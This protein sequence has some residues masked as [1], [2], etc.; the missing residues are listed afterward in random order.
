MT[1]EKK[2]LEIVSLRNRI[3]KKVFLATIIGTFFLLASLW[4]LVYSTSN[5]RERAAMQQTQERLEDFLKHDIQIQKGLNS[6]LDILPFRDDLIVLVFDKQEHLL[7]AS[8]QTFDRI[9]IGELGVIE[10]VRQDSRSYYRLTSL[11]Q[12][13]DGTELYLQQYR[14]FF[15]GHIQ[16]WF[17]LVVISISILLLAISFLFTVYRTVSDEVYPIRKLNTAFR[18]IIDDSFGTKSQIL[19]EDGIL[20]IQQIADNYNQL[21]L[22]MEEQN[23]KQI[24]FISDVSHELRTPVTVLK[25]YINML[26]RWGRE[27]EVVLEESL[28][29]S[30]KEAQRMEI[31]IKDMLDM[32]RIQGNIADHLDDVTDVEESILDVVDNFKVLRNDFKFVFTENRELLPLAQIYQVH[33]EQMIV[34]LIDNAIKYSAENKEIEISATENL[35][36][37]TIQVLVRDHGQG[38]SQEDLKHIFDRF[39]RASKARTSKDTQAGVGIGLSI[40]KKLA[41]AYSIQVSVRSEPGV[42]TEFILD[43]PQVPEEK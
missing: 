26:L 27:D 10:S 17:V 8:D 18:Q 12:L 36:K 6:Y 34:I 40:L 7:Y 21:I 4:A 42:G 37:Q 28:Q 2:K 20:E 43:I 30:L 14:S 35:E 22:N 15:S 16:L 13:D 39:Y 29:S 9:S 32:I 31:M 25:G 33:F 3:V 11:I 1:D 19:Y 23:A 38:I 5:N 41:D 24:Q